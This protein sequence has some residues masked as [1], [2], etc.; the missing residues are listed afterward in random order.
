MSGTES[1]LPEDVNREYRRRAGYVLRP[2]QKDVSSLSTGE[3]S[4]LS[5]EWWVKVR[6]CGGET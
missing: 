6:G 5:F 2:V 4:K 1:T 3:S